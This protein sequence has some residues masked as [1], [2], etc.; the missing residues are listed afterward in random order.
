MIDKL[1]DFCGD[2]GRSRL[3]IRNQEFSLFSQ[4]FLIHCYNSYLLE[5]ENKTCCFG[6]LYGGIQLQQSSSLIP[7]PS[8]SPVTLTRENVREIPYSRPEHAVKTTQQNV[9][10]LDIILSLG[11]FK[12]QDR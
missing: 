12:T 6:S 9:K 8:L 5:D 2:V 4:D 11:A 7:S 3:V 1:L 10:K